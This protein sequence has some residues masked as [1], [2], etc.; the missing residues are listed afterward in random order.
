[1]PHLILTPVAIADTERLRL[2]LRQKN[3]AAAQRATGAI[4]NAI[5][6]LTL[7][8]EAHRV[9]VDNLKLRELVI[10]FGDSGYIALYEYDQS[11]DCVYVLAIKHQLENGF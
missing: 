10:P 7:Y 4:R 8:P 9:R 5:R 11:E 2:F 3:P 1:M 6:S